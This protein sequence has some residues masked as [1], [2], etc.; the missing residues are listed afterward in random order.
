MNVLKL[1]ERLQQA[2]LM[3]VNW[4]NYNRRMARRRAI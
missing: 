3:A 2:A 1:S 4:S